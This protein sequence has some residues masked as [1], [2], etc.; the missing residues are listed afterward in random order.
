MRRKKSELTKAKDKL[1]ALC[2][3]ITRKRYG[4][5]CF[6]CPARELEGS[7]W[8]TGHF[9]TDSVCSTEL[10]YDLANLRPQCF[11]CNIHKSGNW[12]AYEARLIREEGQEYVDELKQRNRDTIGNKYGIFWIK[13]K[14]IEYEGILKSLK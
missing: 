13:E 7:N 11:S 10:S 8:H 9:I 3:A 5:S 14:I 1:W 6:T 4:N 12:P 2:K